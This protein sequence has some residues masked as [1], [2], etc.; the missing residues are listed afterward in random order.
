[1]TK[2]EFIEFVKTNGHLAHLTAE[3]EL[4]DACTDLASVDQRL[5]TPE[6]KCIAL[7]LDA[8]PLDHG[9]EDH[10]GKRFWSLWRVVS[11]EGMPVK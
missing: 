7:F 3:L 11:V 5:G 1:M 6:N 4:V 8:G 9:I 10:D 2:N